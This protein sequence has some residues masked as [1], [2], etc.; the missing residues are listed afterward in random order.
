MNFL[1]SF[2]TLLNLVFGSLS[3][4]YTINGDFRL[5]ALFILI[6]VVMDALDGK[7]AR[8]FNASSEL[9]KQLDSLSDLV[10]FGVAPALLVLTMVGQSSVIQYSSLILT[11]ISVIYILCGAFRLARFNISN[12]TDHF[13]GIP[14][15]LAGTIVAV[16]VLLLPSMSILIYMALLVVLAYLMVSKITVK[17]F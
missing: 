15:T 13:E 4:I 17:K 1:P 8:R 6:A 12:I 10:S 16:V 9:G 2:V 11:I 3:V 7:V 14:I 5:A